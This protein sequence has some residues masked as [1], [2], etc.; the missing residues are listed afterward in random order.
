M[1][2][3]TLL[4]LTSMIEIVVQLLVTRYTKTFQFPYK[5]HRRRA[6]NTDVDEVI[7]IFIDKRT[8]SVGPLYA[9][10]GSIILSMIITRT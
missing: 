1:D 10:S 7:V 9:A 6:Y 2:D 4:S 3:S 5:H 8:Y